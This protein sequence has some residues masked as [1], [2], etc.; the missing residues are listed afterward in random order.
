MEKKNV[1]TV[2]NKKTRKEVDALGKAYCNFLDHGKTER[3]CIDQIVNRI[4]KEGYME[5]DQ[6]IKENKTF[7]IQ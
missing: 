5:L 1:W 7:F 2:Y 3:E 6:L 4:E